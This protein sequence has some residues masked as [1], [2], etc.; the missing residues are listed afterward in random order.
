M[1]YRMSLSNRSSPAS[2]GCLGV[3]L[4][5]LVRATRFEVLIWG[6]V[7]TG[8]PWGGLRVLPRACLN[9]RGRISA[10]ENMYVVAAVACGQGA[11]SPDG[12][13]RALVLV[14]FAALL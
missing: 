10:L 8:H 9:G 5:G 12:H 4:S 14:D 6:L 11:G 13:T 2:R 7:R 1:W 3:L